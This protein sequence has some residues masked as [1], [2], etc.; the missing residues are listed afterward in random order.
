M[1]TLRFCQN[2]IEIHPGM[3]KAVQKAK[4]EF[5]NVSIEIEPC[6]GRCDLCAEKAI[7]LANED[8][9]YGDSSHLLFERMKNS[10]GEREVAAPNIRQ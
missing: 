6:L 3:E 8:L 1:N 2:N 5:T 4:E 9:V 10:I 7:A